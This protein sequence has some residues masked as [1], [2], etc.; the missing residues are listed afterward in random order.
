[1]SQEIE[2]AIEM[3]D[4]DGAEA[5]IAA[6]LAAHP[7]DHWLVCRLASTSYQRQCYARAL[8]L[9]SQALALEPDC[10]LALWERA[11]ALQA[12]GCPAEALTVYEQIASRGVDSLARGSCGEGRARARGL[13][14]DCLF[15][16]AECQLELG[17]KTGAAA[18]FRLHLQHRG[19]GCHSIYTL[20]QARRSLL[21]AEDGDDRHSTGDDERA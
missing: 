10:P 9:S 21:N 3:E 2:R 5:L 19:R 18:L 17:D 1:M 20:R 4:W 11:V 12:L 15:G 7:R 13:Y 6:D 8:E 16:E 14:A